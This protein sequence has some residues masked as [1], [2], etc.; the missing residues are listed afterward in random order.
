MMKKKM[1][2]QEKQLSDNFK[3]S[4]FTNS[5]TAEKLHIA[6]IPSL[7]DIKRLEELCV[8]L[9]QPIRDAY[10]APIKVT[11]GYRSLRL[12][13]AVG[14]VKASA[15]LIGYAADIKPS[16]GSINDF[17]EW[18]RDFLPKSG[19]TWDQCII[20]KK[21]KSKWLHIGYKNQLGLQRQQ[22]F[23]LTVK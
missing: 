20:E 3:L 11:S 14:G 13:N 19:L 8:K 17:I 2:M 21:G 10:G 15:H 22:L 4:E 16:K 5:A 12:N 23:E 18:L 1:M 7:R 9:L 6:N